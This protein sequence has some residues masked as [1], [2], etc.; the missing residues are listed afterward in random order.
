[1]GDGFIRR[2]VKEMMIARPDQ[3]KGLIIFKH[4]DPT[5]PMY[6][7]L[8]VEP[9]EQA[10]FF[11]DGKPAGTFNQPG[12]Y[13]LDSSNIPFLSNLIDSFT[14]GNV[15][16]AEIFFVTTREFPEVKFGGRIGAVE[17]PKSGVGVQT[18]VHG[19]F[20]L[21][22]TD[23]AKLLVGLVGLG[24]AD[25]NEQFLGWF[26]EQVLKSTRERIAR[27]LVEKQYPLLNVTSG[28]FTSEI[29]AAVLEAVRKDVEPYGMRIVRLGNF[30]VSIGEED[31]AELKKLYRDAAYVRM[32]GGLQ[33]YQQFA[34]GKAMLGA[35][36]GLAQGGGGSGGAAGLGAGLGVGFGLA[37]M[38]QQAAA[39]AAG[40]P[41]AAP[42]PA[43]GL[44]QPPGP[45]AA[46]AA[47]ANAP[48]LTAVTCGKCGR[49]VAPGKFCAECGQPLA[50]ARRFCSGCGAELTA[51]A[52]FCSGCGAKV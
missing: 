18:M 32:A 25:N 47:V 49:T 33:G 35:G 10:L 41:A 2:G 36:E 44:G 19:S 15:F 34:A 52:K 22:V 27:L 24:R 4:P 37:Q 20:S 50:P 39:P 12:R 23:P 30:V 40:A 3:T 31:E 17:D 8:T 7:Q 21:Q 11:R 29:E 26:R 48:T 6:S 42:A 14:G 16:I 9:D 46:P 38:F 45:P 43:G 51:G 13:T 28:A 5:I 1:M